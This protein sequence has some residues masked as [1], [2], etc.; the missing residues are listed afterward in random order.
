MPPGHMLN[1]R[2]NTSRLLF[3]LLFFGPCFGQ[4]AHLLNAPAQQDKPY[5]LLIS[6]DGFRYDYAERYHATNLLAIGK[7]A[8]R[9]K[10]DPLVPHHHLPESHTPSSPATIPPI[11]AWSTIRFGI[12]NGTRNLNPATPGIYRRQ[13]GGLQAALGCGR[14]AREMRAASFFWPGS[15]SR[16]S[17]ACVPRIT[18]NT[19]D[20]FPTS[21]ASR[22]WSIG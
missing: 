8:S 2:K 15:D 9:R 11:T 10:A 22:K 12:R 14:A 5:V 4:P 7:G 17:N 16:K 20:K 13:L 19:M 18:R 6:L 21:G 3:L 1:S